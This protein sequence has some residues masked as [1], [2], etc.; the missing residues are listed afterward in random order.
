MEGGL[1]GPGR[2][3]SVSGSSLETGSRDTMVTGKGAAPDAETTREGVWEAGACVEIGAS[4]R[5]W[6]AAGPKVDT[7]TGAG[8]KVNVCTEAGVRSEADDD[9]GARVSV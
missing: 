1:G 4:A 9:T 7:G 5:V 2:N 3:V 8:L 6:A